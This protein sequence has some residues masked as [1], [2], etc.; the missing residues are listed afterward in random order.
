MKDC[1]NKY[2][3]KVF[4]LFMLLVAA[5]DLLAQEKKENGLIQFSGVIVDGD[6]LTPIPFAH[7]LVKNTHRGTISDYYGFFSFVAQKNDTLEFSSVGYKKAYFIIPDTL[8]TNRYSLI[9]I[10]YSDTILLKEVAIY[11]WPSKEQF[12]EAF[13]SLGVPDDDLQRARKNL[14]MIE[15]QK[16]AAALPMDGSMNYNY[17]MQ[18]QQSRLY[19]AGQ[20]PPINLMNPIAWANFI[21]AWKAGDLKIKNE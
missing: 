1:L 3:Q 2:F 12:K 18:Q 9:Q 5:N 6:S 15:M 17:Q 8:T 4:F 21:K 16:M 14:A 20:A 19:Y 13:L 11:P 7:V 10:L